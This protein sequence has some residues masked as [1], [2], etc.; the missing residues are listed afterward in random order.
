MMILQVLYVLFC[1][2]MVMMGVGAT[3]SR[4]VVDD[5]REAAQPSVLGIEPA[6]D[7]R[8]GD[9]KGGFEKLI[10]PRTSGIVFVVQVVQGIRRAG[11]EG[12]ADDEEAMDGVEGGD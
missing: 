5:Q 6:P 3:G 9:E 10:S 2:M 12:G 11:V 7:W 4:V 8:K 1:S